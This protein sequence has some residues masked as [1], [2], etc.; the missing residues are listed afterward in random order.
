[1]KDSCSLRRCSERIVARV[2]CHAYPK[3]ISPN[4]LDDGG[5]AS[6]IRE[7]QVKLTVT[8][9]KCEPL[10]PLSSRALRGVLRHLIR[11]IAGYKSY[12]FQSVPINHFSSACLSTFST[13]S[14]TFP[15]SIR[16]DRMLGSHCI[17]SL[18]FSEPS[19]HFVSVPPAQS[20]PHN[21]PS[22]NI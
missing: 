10:M 11:S 20:A 17:L 9:A 22:F 18:D 15:C 19:P 5:K 16:F 7:Q 3:I 1:M 8:F 13:A 2:G 12:S 4:V 6:R 21:F 14:S